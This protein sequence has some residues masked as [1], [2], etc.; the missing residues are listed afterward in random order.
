MPSKRFFIPAALH[1]AACAAFAQCEAPAQADGT[2]AEIVALTGQGETRARAAAPWAAA[3]LAQRLPPGADVR[4]LALSSAALLLADRTQIR[5]AAQAQVRLCDVRPAQTRLELAV[6]RLWARA[7]AQPVDLQLQTP[8][9]LAAV[10]GTDWDVE[11]EPQGR[12]TLTVLSG[13]IEVSNAQGRV[14]VGPAEQAT[15]EPGQ[16]PVKRTLVNPRERVQWVMASRLAPGH[17]PELA[18]PGEPWRAQALEALRGGRI[19]ALRDLLGGVPPG[20][21]LAERLRAETEVAAGDLEAAQRRLLAVWQARHDSD[22]ADAAAR[23][24]ELLAALDRAGEARAFIATARAEAPGAVPLLLADADARRLDGEGDAALALYQ[25]AVDGAQGPAAQA[26]ALAGR[27]RALRERGDLAAARA[28]L[29]RAVAL[30]PHDAGHLAE[31]A[32]ADT[33]ALRHGAAHAGFAA[34]LAQSG[35]DYV[36]LAGD[37]LLALQQG[38]PARARE[39]LLK[40][41]VIEP[42]YA[43]AQAW[44][45]V[46]EYRLGGTAAAFDAL[47]RARQADPNDPLP[48]QIEAM[49][50][51]DA[52][53]PEAAIAAAREAL[54]RLPYLKSLNPLASDS[55]GSANLGKA[56]G[57]F[58]LEHWARAY[59]QASYYPL[60]AGS[61]FFL[62]NRYESDYSRESEL[63]Q[64][65]LS[66]PTVFG[67]SEK[68][69]P[70]LPSEGREASM[71]LSLGRE[72]LR[73]TA[74][75]DV[76]YRGFTAAPLPL[77]WLVRA[78]GSAMEPREGPPATQ[79]RMRSQDIDIALG[80]RPTERLGLFVLHSEGPMRYRFP[81]GLDYGNGITFTGTAHNRA[82]RTD[83]GASWRWSADAQTWLKLHHARTTSALVLDDAQWGPQDYG[84]GATED[85]LFLRHTVQSG[86]LRWSLGWEGVRRTADSVIS[87]DYIATPRHNT[88]RYDMPWAAAEWSAGPWTLYAAATW[89]RLRVAQTDALRDSLT[90]ED[91]ADPLYD[92]AR[93][94]RRLL[95]R[96][97][98]SYRFGPARAL[99]W[100][101]QESLRAPGTHTLSPV[102]TGAIP[103]DYQYQLPGSLA[104]K[105]AAQIDWEFGPH[106]FGVAS[107]SSQEITNARMAD[108]RLF[109]QV[110][111]TL[112]DSVGTI[113]P[114]QLTA[115]TALDPYQDQPLFGHGRLRQAGAAINQVL[116]P[117][118]SAFAGYTWANGVNQGAG[119]EGLRLPGVARH[120]A[121]LGSTW[122]HAGRD[123]SLVRLVYRGSRFADEA[124]ATPRAPGWTLSLAHA[125]ESSDRRW[126][127]IAT[128][129]GLLHEG[130]KPSLWFLL[131]WRP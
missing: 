37:G 42:R 98:A 58:G 4:T 57:D 65:Y 7:K 126:L 101:Y 20:D 111:G 99:H 68:Q 81:Q 85:G 127:F 124:N 91:L 62:A 128:A 82:E 5:M 55:Q 74:T 3:A 76:A 27:G 59:A 106:T 109:A 32:T 53:E 1:L 113:A 18:E 100:A 130:E 72:P 70:V 105:N 25:A 33:Q 39:Q 61:H 40:A 94:A 35:D 104:R 10:R 21:A 22:A 14:D 123:F 47:A 131:R 119:F 77:A 83:A 52:G 86:A 125:M 115:Q 36:A 67:A 114:V 54:A 29:A 15:V 31:A 34:A 112:F 93:H 8:A 69:P 129:Q 73:G 45:A 64:G 56:L 122:R 11:V 80:A 90:G 60:W 24:A 51:N 13:R 23:R 71:G 63:F 121:V 79:Y 110:T 49:L 107:V 108:G 19:A 2:A 66:D 84:Y 16:A 117:R 95:P 120:T 30:Q 26:A 38:E 6:G 43:Q 28:A 46:A 116:A 50:R 44:L 75:G 78:N 17:W 97:G 118:W 9:A 103:I 12:T 92:G 96:V 87:D 48:W 41:L 89:P 102:A 88:E